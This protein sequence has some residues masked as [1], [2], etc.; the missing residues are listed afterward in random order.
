MRDWR[1]IWQMAKG[2]GVQPFATPCARPKFRFAFAAFRATLAR[3]QVV[4]P[5]TK[6]GRRMSGMRRTDR[7]SLC[8]RKFLSLSLSLHSQPLALRSP[9]RCPSLSRSN[10]PTPANTNKSDTRFGAGR[11]TCVNDLS[12]GRALALAPVV[13]LMQPQ[14]QEGIRC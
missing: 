3:G 2:Q 14:L 8:R 9:S 4:V 1:E 7:R 11:Q 5:E 13:C 6:T 12:R 10:R